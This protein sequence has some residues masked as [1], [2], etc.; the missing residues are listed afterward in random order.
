M[1]CGEGY[2][3][4]SMLNANPHLGGHFMWS[5]NDYARGAEEQTMYSGAVDMNRLPKFSYYLMQSMRPANVSQPGL[6]EGPWCLWPPTRLGGTA[7]S[8][9]EIWVFSNCD[10][11]RLYRNGRLIGSQ[12]RQ[13]Q[14][15]AWRPR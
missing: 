14:T 1:L 11:V 10:E 13:E 8:S 3:D 5:F 12:T 6:Y 15:P 7:S 2:F 9:S 4:W